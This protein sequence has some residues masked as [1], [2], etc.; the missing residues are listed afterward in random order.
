MAISLP[1]PFHGLTTTKTPLS[2]SLLHS[3][4][5]HHHLLPLPTAHKKIT[6]NLKA[7]AKDESSL[8]S[9]I[10]ELEKTQPH[11]NQQQVTILDEDEL[12]DF[13]TQ[14][15]RDRDRDR[16]GLSDRWQEIMGRDDWAGLLDPID[17]LLRVEL[18]RYGE[19]A[20]AC[21]DAFDFD[22][23][24][25]YC[26][27]CKYNRRKFFQSLGMVGCGYEVSRYLYATSNI[28]LPNF[29]TRSRWNKIWSQKANWA[30]YV[31]VSTDEETVRLG[32]REVVI[33]WRGTVTQLEWVHDLMD[34]LRPV[35]EEGFPCPDP[36][37][38]VESGF[39]DLYTDK[40][41]ACRFCRYWIFLLITLKR[42]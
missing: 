20:Q 37:V 4:P 29:F 40:D 31:A 17:Q 35:T 21:Y 8:S 22:P 16:A 3:S 18:I 1:S 38:K 12:D 19:M 6:T 39:M 10:T 33:A 36:T 11:Y 9:I 24:S 14:Q 2:P 28:N 15:T 30:G 7:L 41:P 26:G 23:F 34:F 5:N 27:C 32:R 25:R 42:K 13:L